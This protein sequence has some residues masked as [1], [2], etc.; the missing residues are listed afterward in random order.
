MSV[1]EALDVLDDRVGPLE[2]RASLLPVEQL[3]L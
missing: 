3:D 1:V 2:A